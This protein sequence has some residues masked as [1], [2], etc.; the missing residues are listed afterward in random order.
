MTEKLNNQRKNF[1]E[2]IPESLAELDS[3]LKYEDVTQGLIV[4]ARVLSWNPE[5]NAVNVHFGNGIPGIISTED[6]SIYPSKD[7]GG[8]PSEVKFRLGKKVICQVLN[9]DCEEEQFL[10]SRVL[11]MKKRLEQIELSQV[12]NANITGM[13]D[14]NLFVDLGAGVLGKVHLLELSRV[15]VDNIADLG[16]QIG[17]DISLITIR[18]EYDKIELSKRKLYPDYDKTKFYPGQNVNAKIISKIPISPKPNYAGVYGL[19]VENNPN[20]EGMADS[21]YEM[22]I[23]EEVKCVVRVITE[24]GLKLTLLKEK[25][26]R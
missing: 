21:F 11:T 15:H 7:K 19:Q 18:K 14:D 17:Q 12:I 9:Y 3:T 5:K 20:I 26:K 23:G 16:Y 22:V 8:V 1:Q 24:R 13:T 2:L 6:I 10:L 4:T 25:K